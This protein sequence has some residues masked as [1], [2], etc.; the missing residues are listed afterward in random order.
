M[1]QWL[2][3]HPRLR[4]REQSI[5]RGGVTA[6]ATQDPTVSGAELTGIGI[7]PRTPL[8]VFADSG[9]PLR[10]T[11]P[12]LPF[13]V[14]ISMVSRATGETLGGA[15]SSLLSWRMESHLNLLLRLATSFPT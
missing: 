8:E 3:P 4:S 11:A 7:V 15:Q 1:L 5:S 10:T 6:A 13:R 9:R 12:H 2:Q 14:W